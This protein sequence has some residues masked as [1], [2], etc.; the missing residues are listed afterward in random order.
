MRSSLRQAP[1]ELLTVTVPASR[2]RTPKLV[3][4]IS[5]TPLAGVT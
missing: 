5:T 2:S 1:T 4:G 3:T